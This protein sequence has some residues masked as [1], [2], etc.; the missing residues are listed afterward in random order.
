MVCVPGAQFAELGNTV[1]DP[2][3]R[4]GGLAW[5]VGDA[6]REWSLE[7]GYDAYLHY[8]TTDHDI[9]QR[10]SVETGFECGVML[11]YIPAETD[12]QAGSGKTYLR[13]AATIVCNPLRQTQAS[14][15]M[16][17]HQYATVLQ[18]LVSNSPLARRWQQPA[19]ATVQDLPAAQSSCTL[20][21]AERRGLSR[22]EVAQIGQDIKTRLDDLLATVAPCMQIDFELTDVAI[23]TGVEAAIEA[24]FVFCGWL[25][26]YRA[27]DVLRLQRVDVPVTDVQ[28]A[29]VNA[30]AQK[31]IRVIQREMAIG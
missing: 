15:L 8:P 25:P 22:L 27:S 6:L 2:D 4:G 1:V 9:M 16:L 23:D 21:V 17:P 11:G 18:E 10:K 13:S 12:G 30:E 19:P 26:G 20:T 28:P 14:D 31:M 5:R 7:L 24:G 29:V 3:A